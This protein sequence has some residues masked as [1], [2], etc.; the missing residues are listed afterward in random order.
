MNVQKNECVVAGARYDRALAR[1]QALRPLPAGS[2]VPQPTAV[3]PAENVALLEQYCQWL[4]NGGA[5][6]AVIDQH[7]IPMAGHVLGL[8][9]KPHWQLDLDAD[10]E[11]AWAYVQ[12]RQPSSGWL[13]NCR[14]SLVWFRRF[15]ELERGLVR[16]ADKDVFG[17]AER[18]RVGL[19][20]WL[21]EQLEKFLILRQANWRPSRKAQATYQFWHKQTRI[22]HWLVEEY[23][24]H[25]E[26][27]SLNRSQLYGYIDKRL[28]EG[29]AIGSVNQ[30]LYNFQGF[31]RFLERRGWRIPLAVLSMPGLKPADS[32]PRFLTDAQVGRLR[33]RYHQR[34]AEADTP[35]RMRDRHLDLACF[36]L[37]W[38]GGMRLCELQ[39]LLLEDLDLASQRLLV[40]QTKGLKD[41][42]VY[43]TEAAVAAVQRYLEHRGPGSTDHVFLY[44]HRPVSA[45]LVRNRLKSAG[46]EVGVKVTPHMLR[47]TFGTQLVNAGCDVASIQSLLGHKRMNTTMIY[48]RVHDQ[49]VADHYYK[50]MALIEEQVLAPE[51]PALP[52]EVNYSEPLTNNAYLLT[53]VEN[54]AREP[55][56]SSQ[57]AAVSQLQQGIS[58]M[59]A[60]FGC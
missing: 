58:T 6:R 8:N 43:L 16:P 54:L 9:L 42:A 20:D 1:S 29:Y 26:L 31:L 57:Q 28:A 10:L 56:T 49:T 12:L 7:R 52:T 51:E 17:N 37:L 32:L 34:L 35:T 2:V 39:D 41:R 14:H 18:F 5:A 53:L 24:F 25:D 40:R 30:E 21:I 3:W 50:A 59:V 27:A 36:Y 23:G 13:S 33:D 45:E 22:W 19:P 44:R 60:L 55:L 38:Q 47:H 4:V 11:K 48:A 15:L 46:R